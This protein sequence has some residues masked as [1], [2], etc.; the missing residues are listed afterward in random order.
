MGMQAAE[1][2]ERLAHGNDYWADRSGESIFNSG[3][4]EGLH[5]EFDNCWLSV[6][7]QCQ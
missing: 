3:F 6:G 7:A 1:C 2:E 5:F 4:V